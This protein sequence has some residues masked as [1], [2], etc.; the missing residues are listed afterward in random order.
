E[1]ERYEMTYIIRA[2]NRARWNWSL[3]LLV[4]ALAFDAAGGCSPGEL[5]TESDGDALRRRC[6][7]NSRCGRR[8]TCRSCPSDC[9]MCDGSS[10]VDDSGLGSRDSDSS[11][12]SGS[13]VDSG[14]LVDG[15][16]FVDS[17]L[18]VDRGSVRCS[19]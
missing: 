7:H 19:R 5:S 11:V 13:S 14:S 10:S 12:N 15:G 18:C 2:E 17:G 1:N 3:A 4:G 6:N 16:S 8:E 9:G